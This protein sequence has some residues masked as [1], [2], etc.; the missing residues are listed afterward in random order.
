M[1]ESGGKMVQKVW[2]SAKEFSVTLT[3]LCTQKGLYGLVDKTKKVEINFKMFLKATLSKEKYKNTKNYITAQ[4]IQFSLKFKVP[5]T[6]I[7]YFEDGK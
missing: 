5:V 6:N 3:I 1:Y 7:Y 4:K 2:M